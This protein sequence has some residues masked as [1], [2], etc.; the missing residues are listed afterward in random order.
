MDHLKNDNVKIHTFGCKVNT[1]D[2][3]L[4][5]KSLKIKNSAKK[6]HIINSCA[7]TAEASK[8]AL[9]W[10]RKLK[11][12]DPDSLV[13][14]TG[15]SAQVEDES[16]FNQDS[17]DLI[18]ANSH[19]S[20]ISEIVNLK[21]ENSHSEQKLF[22]SNIFKNEELGFG[23]G[24]E[25]S[26]TR[27]FLKVQDG[28]NSFCTFCVIPYARGTSRSISIDQLVQKA[29][30]LE[31][32]GYLEIVLTGIHIGDFEDEKF[33]HIKKSHLAVLVDEILKNTK[34]IRLRLSSLEP[35]EVTEDLLD[36][37]KH[38]RMN[39][40]FHLSI[41]SANS[42]VL[43][44]MKRKYSQD[45]IISCF[46]RIHETLPSVFIGMDVIAGFP[47]ET[48]LQFEDTYRCLS[49]LNW[50]RLHVFPYSVRPG[51]RAEKFENLVSDAEKSIRAQ[52]LR[53]LSQ[54]KYDSQAMKQLNQLKPVLW[55]NQ[56]K[57]SENYVR[58]LTLDYF[59]VRVPREKF[60]K[61]STVKLLAYNQDLQKGE[62]YFLAEAFGE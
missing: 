59:N 52:R 12:Q 7:V 18:I 2:S 42:E 9:R 40:H 50:N 43:K 57:Q 48:D 55:L 4:L 45:D 17:V 6:I 51:T 58:G 60:V 35:I 49:Q 20:Q 23:G 44:S 14:V 10:T 56:G 8:E 32:Q 13:V 37:Y 53:E 41:Q 31:A 1:Y 39:P 46:K 36:L 47:T 34:N 61:T 24:E 25:K 29:K 15:C 33:K 27:S 54:F 30:E 26:H 28:C 38:E 21:I 19:K 3:G 22:K 11:K 16:Y 62:G 5:E